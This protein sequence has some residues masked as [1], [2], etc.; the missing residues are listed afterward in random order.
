VSGKPFL[1]A[2]QFIALPIGNRKLRVLLSGAVP[3][4]FDE[5]KTPGSGGL[6]ER[7]KFSVHSSQ[8]ASFLIWFNKEHVFPRKRCPWKIR[9]ILRSTSRIRDHSSF[10]LLQSPSERASVAHSLLF[11]GK[12]VILS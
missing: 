6:K 10:S 1:A 7:R 5:L 9:V 11:F 12:C 8:I 4:I 2:A 3:K